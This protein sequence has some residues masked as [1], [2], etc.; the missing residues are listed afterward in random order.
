MS[1]L[2][3]ANN[4]LNRDE[5]LKSQNV[6]V[7]FAQHKV[8]ALEADCTVLLKANAQLQQQLDEVMG[9]GKKVAERL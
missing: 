1:D 5:Y 2:S 3:C 4:D 9:G 8:K 7:M 6:A